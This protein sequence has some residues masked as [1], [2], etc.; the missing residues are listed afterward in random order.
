[1]PLVATTDEDDGWTRAQHLEAADEA[2]L[3]STSPPADLSLGGYR[4]VS[5]WQPGAAGLHAHKGRVGW[6]GLGLASLSPSL[7][8]TIGISAESWFPPWLVPLGSSFSGAAAAP[9]QSRF[10]MACAVAVC[11]CLYVC[12]HDAHDGAP[13]VH[14]PPQLHYSYTPPCTYALR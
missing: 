5:Q 4:C 1:M 12:A 13:C 8:G 9:T 6:W 3:L 11:V 7:A 10:I 14:A 2:A